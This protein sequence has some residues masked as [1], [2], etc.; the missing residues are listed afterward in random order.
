MKRGAIA[1][2]VWQIMFAFLVLL[3]SVTVSFAKEGDEA[4]GGI[5]GKITTV[6][7]QPAGNVTIRVNGTSKTTATDEDGSFSINNL[8]PGTYELQISL[9]GYETIKRTVKVEKNKPTSISIQLTVSEKQLQEVIVKTGT[10][11]FT[12]SS[13]D[14]VAKMPLKN[15]ENAQVYSVVAKSLLQEQLVSNQDDALK[16]IPGLYKIWGS[17]GRSGDGGSYFTSRG[18]VTQSM[19]RNGIA[20]KVT[21]NVDVANVERIESIKGPSATL[22]GSTLTSYGG[23]INRVTKKPYDSLGGEF[24]YSFGSYAYNRLTADINTPLNQDKTALFRLNASYNSQNSFQDFGYGKSFF[25][26]PSFSYKVN[27]RLT[28]SID[29]EIFNNDATANQMIYFDNS[30]TIPQLGFSRADQMNFNF[31]RSFMSNDF[32][33]KTRTVNV[34]AQ[35]NYKMSDHWVS[36]T[37]LSSS[38]NT[39][40]GILPWFYLLANNQMTRNAWYNDGGDN[41]LEI[42]QNFIGDFKIGKMRNRIVAGLDFSSID[43]KTSYNYFKDYNTVFDTINYNGPANNYS[44]FNKQNVEPL[45]AG[46]PAYKANN[47]QYVYSAYVSDV[48]NITDRLIASA[49]LRIDRFDN[50]GTYSPDANS[51]SGAYAQTALSPKFGLIYQVVKDKVSVF[52]NYQNG[53]QNQTGQDSL[54]HTFKPQ[55]ATQWEGGV[56]VNAFAGKLVSTISYYDITVDNMLRSVPGSQFQVQDGTQVSK[57][58]EAELIAN[59]LRGLNIV[60]GYGYNDSKMVKADADVNGRRPVTAGPK[61]LVNLWIS[62]R[63]TTGKLNGLGA[64]FGGNYASENLTNN[65]AKQGV[66]ILPSYTILNAAIFY[67]QPKFRLSLKADNLTNK[68]YWIGWTTINAQM[69]RRVSASIAFKF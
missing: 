22:F 25:I 36:Q 69:L 38:N 46:G 50:K 32:V 19:F 2:C 42:Q 39:S 47:T 63:F 33:M 43:T 4:V 8:Q 21:S 52:G 31:K 20:G 28:F 60:A 15:L 1:K 48:F 12:K 34:F 57:G 18:F 24:S 67:D 66:F 44:N 64:G 7:G 45:F 29:A 13:S 61:N 37:A 14:Y 59:P 68:E 17:T 3:T 55:H 49:A 40:K 62:Y 65:Y 53:F 41:I 11:K 26:A 9:V 6:D 30:I 16:N 5:S 35:A 56:K 27:D 51:T 23:L 54:L 58:F 10:H